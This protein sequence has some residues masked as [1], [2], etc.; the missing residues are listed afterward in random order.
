MVVVVL[1]CSLSLHTTKLKCRKA[2][3]TTTHQPAGSPGKALY[4]RSFWK[5]R[6][7]S[8]ETN[9]LCSHRL[10]LHVPPVS[11]KWEGF[12]SK[13]SPSAG[14]P[15]GQ[16]AHAYSERQ[17]VTVPGVAPRDPQERCD[18][19]PGSWLSPSP[20]CTAGDSR[21]GDSTAHLST[22]LPGSLP[23]K[24][25]KKKKVV[26]V[27]KGLHAEYVNIFQLKQRGLCWLSHGDYRVA[28]GAHTPDTADLPGARPWQ[29]RQHLPGMPAAFLQNTR[30]EP[31]STPAAC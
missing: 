26:K 4:K 16:R 2:E 8:F 29:R 13:A 19:P 28:S 22:S 17:H 20:A 3:N 12:G 23:F 11:N 9:S 7:L 21:E 10:G 6:C 24:L 18:S 15:L 14:G 1:S 31:S 5:R 30:C 25:K 27:S